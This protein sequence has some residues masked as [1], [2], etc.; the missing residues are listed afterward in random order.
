[1]K[2]TDKQIY[3]CNLLIDNG[4]P[5]ELKHP[6][7]NSVEAADAFIK[8]N[9]HYLQRGIVKHENYY[10][11]MTEGGMTPEDFGVLNM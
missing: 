10:Q 7:E 4:A 9:R 11:A 1:M 6:H 8:E 2:A 3:L 5:F